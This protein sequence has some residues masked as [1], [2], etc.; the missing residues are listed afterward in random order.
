[1]I[2]L[3]SAIEAVATANDS[4]RSTLG[5]GITPH[6]ADD[7]A[8]PTYSQTDPAW[9]NDALG[10]TTIGRFGCLITC[11]AMI[12]SQVEGRDVPPNEV[13]SRLDNAGRLQSNGGV[14]YVDLPKIAA[15]PLV[16][17]ERVG[18]DGAELFGRADAVDC[19]ASF[20]VVGVRIG[21]WPGTHYVLT[22][23]DGWI[24]NPIGGRRERFDDKYKSGGI[25]S[26]A[27][28]SIA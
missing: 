25:F 19:V 21:E 20:G 18:G 26:A 22:I 9:A 15:V 11:W 27:V 16:T 28:W 2:G 3:L 17:W 23:G 14:L 10:T 24:I 13:V 4:L 6:S 5:D 12:L 7:H 8:M 1:M